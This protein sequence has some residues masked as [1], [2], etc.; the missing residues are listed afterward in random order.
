[1]AADSQLPGAGDQT[2]GADSLVGT[3]WELQSYGPVGAESAVIGSTPLTLE[4]QA[5]G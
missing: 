1:M 5:D 4:F 3:Q 2:P